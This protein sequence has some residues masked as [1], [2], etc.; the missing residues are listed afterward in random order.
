M[1]DAA[2]VVRFISVTSRLPFESRNSKGKISIRHWRRNGHVCPAPEV[3]SPPNAIF[4]ATGA[5][6][7]KAQ[8]TPQRVPAVLRALM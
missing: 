5:R 6:I 3:T 1:I 8:S 7:R 4:D 2:V